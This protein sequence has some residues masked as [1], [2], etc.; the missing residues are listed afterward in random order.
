MT[1]LFERN[2]HIPTLMGQAVATEFP[3]GLATAGGVMMQ[4]FE[5]NMHI[6]TLKGHALDTEFP[7]SLE[8]AGGL[9]MQLFV[10]NMHIPMLKGQA[11]VINIGAVQLSAG[12]AWR[13]MKGQG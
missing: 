4:L 8:S 12:A 3:M 7:M 11:S 6:P 1:Q 5:G 10:R 2:M 13:G 9:L